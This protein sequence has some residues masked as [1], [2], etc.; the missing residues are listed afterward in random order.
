MTREEIGKRMD[1]LARKYAETHDPKVKR[2]LE[3]LNWRFAR[4][5]RIKMVAKKTKGSEP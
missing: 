5:G 4:V 3:K 1:E 2:E